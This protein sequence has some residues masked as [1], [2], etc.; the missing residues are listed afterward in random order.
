MISNILENI[1]SP[2]I[3]PTVVFLA[4]FPDHQ[5]TAL[6]SPPATTTADN[7]IN[8]SVKVRLNHYIY[9][10]GNDRH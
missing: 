4:I 10:D 8:F 7:F 9:V 1:R 2:S 6:Y 5:N 3:P